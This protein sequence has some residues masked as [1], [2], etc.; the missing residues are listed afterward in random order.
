MAWGTVNVDEQRVRFVVSASRREKSM[1]QLWEEFQIS[2]PTGYEWLPVGH[3]GGG[4][5]GVVEKSR[6]PHHSPEKTP[7]EIEQRVIELRQQRPDW[8]RAEEVGYSAGKSDRFAGD[9]RAP[10]IAA[11]RSGASTGSAPAGSGAL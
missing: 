10:D 1:Q 4:I 5:A 11:A 2:R 7:A 6:R 3:Q 8:E 9:H